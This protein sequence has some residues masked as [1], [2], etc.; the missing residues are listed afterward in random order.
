MIEL[1]VIPD[2]GLDRQSQVIAGTPESFPP[3]HPALVKRE[4]QNGITGLFSVSAAA[5]A[6]PLITANVFLAIH[7]GNKSLNGV[8]FRIEWWQG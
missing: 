5:P 7:V 1:S 6:G 2:L 3:V 4:L 8:E